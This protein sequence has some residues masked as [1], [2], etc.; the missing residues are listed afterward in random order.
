MSGMSEPKRTFFAEGRDIWRR[1]LEAHAATE[2]EVWLIFSKRHLGEPCVS[3]DEAVEEALC[4]GWIDGMLRRIDERRHMVRFTPRR[5]DSR[6][7]QRN[8]QRVER[9]IAAGKMTAAGLA[10]VEHARRTGEW[11]AARGS[12]QDWPVPD[13]L[14]RALEEDPSSRSWF[15]GLALSHRRQY[16]GWIHEAKREGRV[17]VGSPGRWR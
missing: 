9:M 12:L 6:W 16:L 10:L 3:L 15:E 5:K 13:E 2:P 1:W 8:K 7:S 17:N 11:E 4:F 14:R